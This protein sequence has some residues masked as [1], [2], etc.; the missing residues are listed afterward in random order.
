MTEDEKTKQEMLNEIT[1]LR[2][3]LAAKETSEKER[4]MAEEALIRSEKR[5]HYLADAAME[6]ILIHMDGFCFDANQAAAQMFGYT[7]PAELLGI[8]SI[9]FIAPESRA[10]V[11]ARL[12]QNFKHPF[13]A[14]GR[15]RDGGTF[16]MEVRSKTMPYRKNRSVQVTAVRDITAQKNAEREHAEL[17]SQL[18]QS[19]KMEAIGRLAGGVA[20]D[21]N[22]VLSAILGSATAFQLEH[23]GANVENED[24]ENILD[25]CRRGR[26]LTRDLLG[27]ARKGTYT[28]RPFSLNTV[29]QA[30]EGLLARTISKKITIS[31]NLDPRLDHIVGDSGQLEHALMNICIN[32]ADAMENGGTLTITTENISPDDRLV[33]LTGE[34]KPKRFVCL[35]V[36][37][38]GTGMDPIVLERA[39][40]PFFTTKPEGKGT[41]LGLSMVY[42]AI[43]NHG[44][45]VT[46]DSEKGTGTK[47]SFLLPSIIRT[48]SSIPV[49]ALPGA[50]DLQPQK[51]GILLVD[52]ENIVLRATKRVLQ[53]LGY[54][55]F[56][57]DAGESALKIFQQNRN[58]IA[59]V[60]LD[61]IMPNM[62]GTD[63]FYAL[64]K[65]DPTL[66]II[67]CSGYSKD[68]RVDSLLKDGA[69]GFVQKPF[70]LETLSTEVRRGAVSETP[71]GKHP[72][73]A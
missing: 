15:K 72:S 34:L 57:T 47:V 46:I 5:F 20:H 45:T 44:G 35:S 41:G 50:S 65:I 49:N 33:T 61:L 19:Q 21:M 10:L 7:D 18:L 1:Y 66:R 26:D 60:I 14:V 67:I 31:T 38:T 3:Q 51:G 11:K 56:A 42:G 40:E 54:T 63:I 70:D 16:P 59:L 53:K 58:S 69:F 52:D 68:A 39:F 32:A 9:D 55:V 30:S 27:F 4:L 64:R 48:I 43:N 73:I 24:I 8:Q 22:N 29:V 62:D 28:R 17:E 2:Q 12:K 37:D 6:G 23:F 36:S 25:A 13:E 71:P